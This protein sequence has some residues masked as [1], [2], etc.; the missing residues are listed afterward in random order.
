D[1][2]S[3]SS[4]GVYDLALATYEQQRFHYAS[5]Q[6]YNF[7]LKQPLPA[8]RYDTLWRFVQKKKGL[9]LLDAGNPRQ[10]VR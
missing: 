2:E 7:Q 6:I 10:R 8:D 1:L 4:A 3:I 9:G 5:R